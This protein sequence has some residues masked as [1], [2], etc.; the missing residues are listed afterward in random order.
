M[1]RTGAKFDELRDDNRR[2]QLTILIMYTLSEKTE[3]QIDLDIAVIISMVG[4][5]YFN[6]TYISNIKDLA[7]I[8]KDFTNFKTFEMPPGYKD[9][10]R[11][12]NKLS[13]FHFTYYVF[14]VLLCL[15]I[16]FV[17][18]KNCPAKDARRDI[19]EI[20]GLAMNV[21]LPFDFDYFPLKQLVS[22]CQI[23]SV[24]FSYVLS[25]TIS[26]SIMESMEHVMFRLDYVKELF[27]EALKEEESELKK[28]IFKHSVQYHNFIIR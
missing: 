18:S 20:C 11:K 13:I 12:W 23:Y 2:H 7:D 17:Q 9:F 10:A 8:F 14:L 16:T 28:Q 25:S 22:C 5:Y 19:H 6:F 24:F 3:V 27:L 21:W 26:F 15:L 1:G 4:T